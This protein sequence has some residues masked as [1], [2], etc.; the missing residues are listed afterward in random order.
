MTPKSNESTLEVD[1]IRQAQI[2]DSVIG[3]V[4]SF[5]KADKRPTQN[6]NTV[7]NAVENENTVE[8]KND[9]ASDVENA[10]NTEVVSELP[11][12]IEQSRARRS[13]HPSYR[14]TYYRPG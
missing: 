10:V 14:F 8:N 1:D 12:H 2:E 6:E 11:A 9:S 3:K 7:E 13:R 5:I 4:Y